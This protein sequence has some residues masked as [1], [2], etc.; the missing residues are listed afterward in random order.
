MTETQIK[1]KRKNG[2]D[3]PQDRVPRDELL[4]PTKETS[5]DPP[6]RSILDRVPNSSKPVKYKCLDPDYVKYKRSIITG[7]QIKEE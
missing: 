2:R 5:F 4:Y 3:A 7:T 6:V 1:E